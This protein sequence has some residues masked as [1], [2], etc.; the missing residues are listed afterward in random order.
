MNDGLD[1]LAKT[2]AVL[3]STVEKIEE[4]QERTTND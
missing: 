4:I 3:E 1:N 2:M